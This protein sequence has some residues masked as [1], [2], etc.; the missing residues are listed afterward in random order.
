MSVA[1]LDNS[2][3]N[4]V[5]KLFAYP[6]SIADNDTMYLKEAM[7]QE[8]RVHF[9]DAMIKEIKTITPPKVIGESTQEMR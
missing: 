9:L 6:A 8:D 1:M 2:T 4:G 5:V 7:Q 3:L